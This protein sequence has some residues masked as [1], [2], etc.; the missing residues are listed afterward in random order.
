MHLFQ[1]EHKFSVFVPI[2]FDPLPVLL[3][4]E[5]YQ[6]V[7]DHLVHSV[8]QF[9]LQKALLLFFVQNLHTRNVHDD[10]NAKIGL[11]QSGGHFEL[12]EVQNFGE[13]VN[14][15]ISFLQKFCFEALS[16]LDASAVVLEVRGEVTI[17]L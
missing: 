3:V 2:D 16:P 11:R 13:G 5:V 8:G 9:R 10:H 14:G 7:C 1:N 17:R 6:R 12:V 4:Q 15:K